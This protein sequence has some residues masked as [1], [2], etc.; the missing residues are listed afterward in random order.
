MQ[1]RVDHQTSNPM[2]LLN[3]NLRVL[4]S[5]VNIHAYC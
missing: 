2:Q 1:I 4:V 3:Q 5:W